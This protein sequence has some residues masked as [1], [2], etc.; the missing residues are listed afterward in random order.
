[1]SKI[2]FGSCLPVFGNC[3]DRFV[4][5]GYD[6]ES[7][8][9]EEM[10]RRA[11]RVEDLEGVELVGNWHINENN[12]YEIS[13]LLKEVDLE[14]SLLTPDLWTQGKWGK[15]SFTSY[16]KDIREEAL[17]EVKTVMDMAEEVGCNMIDL[18]FGQDGNDYSFQLDYKWAWNQLVENVR[19]CAEHNSNV[20]ICIEYK[21]KEPRKHCIIDSAAKSLLLVNQ[22]NKD[23][24]GVL[25][26][27]GHAWAALENVAETVALLDDADKLWYIHLNDNYRS[28]D[29]DMLVGSVHTIETLELIYWLDKVDY[30]GWYTL[31]IFPYREDGIRTA[32]ESIEWVKGMRKVLQN[33]GKDRILKVIHSGDATE[34]SAMMREMLL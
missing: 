14:V 12:I 28:W 27:I 6:E 2:K 32:E 5:D 22:I 30:D 31:D 33:Y 21:L 3:S 25:L 24:V 9:L 19:E 34:V 4:N 1:M 23:N 20:D 7:V 18:W 16:D 8:S 29:D 11:G 13:E 26:D 10:I 17:Q 15:G